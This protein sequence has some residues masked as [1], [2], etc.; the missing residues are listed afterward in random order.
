MRYANF[1]SDI[2]S[3]CNEYEARLISA[4]DVFRQFARGDDVVWL[5]TTRPEVAVAAIVASL[6]VQVTIPVFVVF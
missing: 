5:V 3:D 2:A 1:A 4:S 6:H